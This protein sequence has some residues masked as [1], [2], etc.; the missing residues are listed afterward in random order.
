M[1][2]RNLYGKTCLQ[3]RFGYIFLKAFLSISVGQHTRS[4]AEVDANSDIS[5]V[6]HVQGR[7]HLS[8]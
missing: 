6:F 4:F 7:Q 3:D 8:K 5:V 1:R 2:W